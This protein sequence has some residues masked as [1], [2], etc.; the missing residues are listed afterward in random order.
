MSVASCYIVKIVGVLL[1]SRGTF[2]FAS[3]FARYDRGSGQ[4]S[5]LTVFGGHLDRGSHIPRDLPDLI[6]DLQRIVTRLTPRFAQR[7][8]LEDD[9]H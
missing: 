3:H 8:E 1:T 4:S 7:C 2:Q 5:E 9:F 6:R